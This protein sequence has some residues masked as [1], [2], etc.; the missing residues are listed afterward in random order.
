MLYERGKMSFVCALEPMSVSDSVPEDIQVY[1]THAFFIQM[2]LAR[3]S[4]VAST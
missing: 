1:I 3:C 2:L 4:D